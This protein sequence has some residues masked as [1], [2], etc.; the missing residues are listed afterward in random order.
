MEKI[1]R[2]LPVYPTNESLG[3]QRSEEAKEGES[4]EADSVG[5]DDQVGASSTFQTW[6]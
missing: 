6:S 2:E 4:G 1:W 5:I 3:K